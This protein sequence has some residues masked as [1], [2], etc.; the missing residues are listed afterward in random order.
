MQQQLGA[1]NE[2]PKT[3]IND[4]NF[5]SSMALC[6]KLTL[7]RARV[8]LRTTCDLIEWAGV[9]FSTINN[10]L[11]SVKLFDRRFAA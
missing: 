5:N 6:I 2:A 4:K 8:H 1:T 9:H 7:S 3:M 11:V 10:D